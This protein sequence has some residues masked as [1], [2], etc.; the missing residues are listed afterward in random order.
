MA[1]NVV[2]TALLALSL[3]A[4]CGVKKQTHAKVLDELA[5]CQGELSASRTKVDEQGTRITQLE[6]ELSTTR[7]AM[8]EAEREKQ[9]RI[10]KLLE[11][12]QAGEQELLD[13]RRQRD[14][15][16]ARLESY[17][18][19]QAKLKELVDTGKLDVEFR[20]GQMVLKLPSE[21]LFASG[22]A[23][24]SRDGKTALA[25]VLDILLEFKDR[26]FMVAG[27]T[28][29]V[30]IRSRKF[31]SNWELSTARALSVLEA[32]VEKGFAP[33]NVAAAGYGEFQPVADND[34][35]EGRQLNRRIEI[36]L[37]PDLSELPNLT[38]D[39]S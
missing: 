39:P 26:R 12:M 14:M 18:Q 25:E 13:L 36:I 31:K 16:T 20:S 38:E 34:S 19:L 15:A 28:D 33:E 30:K 3:G 2:M 21:V 4:G 9:A 29:N 8:T 11:E 7:S 10:T 22:R 27:H 23:D 17:R 35:D 32:M 24:L 1:R 5:T 6:S 37:V